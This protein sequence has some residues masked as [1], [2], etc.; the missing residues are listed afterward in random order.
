MHASTLLRK[1][2]LPLPHRSTEA[3]VDRPGSGHLI[4]ATSS[5]WLFLLATT[6]GGA[7]YV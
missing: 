7:Q 5:M 4:T 1:V 3:T 6:L 2:R